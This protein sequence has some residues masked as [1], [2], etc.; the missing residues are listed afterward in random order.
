MDLLDPERVAFFDAPDDEEVRELLPE[1]PVASK[2]VGLDV[3]AGVDDP[4]KELE[5]DPQ[6]IIEAPVKL[7]RP[8]IFAPPFGG[9]GAWSW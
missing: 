3:E 2:Y 7:F 5:L 6:Q 1:E 8:L 4:G 9:G